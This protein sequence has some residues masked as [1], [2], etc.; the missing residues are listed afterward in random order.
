MYYIVGLGNTRHNAGFFI[1]EQIVEKFHLP[2][3]MK[4]AKYNG[5]I[6]EGVIKGKEVTALLPQTFMNVSGSAVSKLVPRNAASNLLV[7][8]DDIDLPLGEYR[9]SFGRG[10]GGHN[11][12]KSIIESLGTR[13][14]ARLRIGI[15]K[16]N[17]WSGALVRP[18]GEALASFV[19][20]KLSSKDQKTLTE[21]AQVSGD[22]TSLF[23]TEGIEK[24]MNA[25]N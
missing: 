7:V 22:I 11:G 19:L 4:S 25:F 10:D 12:I 20:G 3:P 9:V 17:L 1:V 23:V 15:G 16:K 5:L 18:K 14:F 8:Y 21:I 2:S 6:S 13:D 24:A